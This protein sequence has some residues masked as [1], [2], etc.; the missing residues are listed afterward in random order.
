MRILYHHPGLSPK[1]SQIKRMNISI[2]KATLV[3]LGSKSFPKQ[4]VHLRLI[5]LLHPPK[6]TNQGTNFITQSLGDIK[7]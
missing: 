6:T 5:F 2:A 7:T 1:H 4:E 3:F